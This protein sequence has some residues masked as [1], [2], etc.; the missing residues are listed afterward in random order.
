MTFVMVGLACA[1]TGV[2]T[3]MGAS[4]TAHAIATVAVAASKSVRDVMLLSSVSGSDVNASA[5]QSRLH[6]NADGEWDRRAS[7]GLALT[8][9]TRLKAPADDWLRKF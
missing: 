1:A 9:A 4:T 3:T 7:Q 2:D 8:A 6:P 5:V